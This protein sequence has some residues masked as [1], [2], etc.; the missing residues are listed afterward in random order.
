MTFFDT[1]QKSTEDNRAHV[2]Q[3]PVFEAVRQGRFDRHSYTW[4]L[5]Q[6][7]HHVK[8]TV[9]LMM[10]CAA[11]LRQDQEWIRKALVHYIDD[12]YGHEQW[13][14]NDLA[15]CGVDPKQAS[16][17]TPDANIQLMVAWLYHQID[18]G[19]PLAFFGMVH[20]LEGTSIAVAT[21][22]GQVVQKVLGLPKSA[23]S[24]LFS[25]G[26]LDLEHFEF[27]KGLM[28]QITDPA[29]QKAIIDSAAMVYRLYGNMLHSIPLLAEEGARHHAVA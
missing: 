15:A 19:N 16:E 17:S 6:A 22:T 8:H 7:Y 21:Q 29:D 11:R 13:I 27:F 23:F 5:T 10:A 25:H 18:R 2:M 9:P 20:V 14:L 28:E 26:A 24:Y 1:L 3:A 4:F 12:E